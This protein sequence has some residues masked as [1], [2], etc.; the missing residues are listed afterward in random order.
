[1]ILLNGAGAALGPVAVAI[2]M[3][4]LG[5]SAYFASL[6]VLCATLGGYGMW[7]RHRRASVPSAEKVHFV[8]AQPQAVAGRRVGEAPAS[9]QEAER[10]GPDAGATRLP[11]PRSARRRR[12]RRHR[13]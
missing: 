7:R 4:A 2:L 10:P 8:A 12:H 11:R 13:A 5:P 3:N 9:Q 1:M 6:A